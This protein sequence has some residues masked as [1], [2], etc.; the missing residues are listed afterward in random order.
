MKALLLGGILLASAS[1]SAAT[2]NIVSL[3]VT[4][5]DFEMT[6][7]L[8]AGHS[9]D[10]SSAETVNPA[11]D[12]IAGAVDPVLSFALANVVFG[13]TGSE[14]WLVTARTAGPSSA[15][16]DTVTNQITINLGTWLTSWTQ[17]GVVPPRQFRGCGGIY[18]ECDA[19]DQSPLGGLV[20]GTWNPA[21]NGFEVSWVR[22]IA[23]HPFPAGTGNWTLRGTAIVP[24]PGAGWLLMTALGGLA[25]L[26]LRGRPT[27]SPP[28]SNP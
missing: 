16:V 13:P 1:A 27:A 8:I 15:T 7:Q 9:G 4:D 17:T 25:A 5:F 10:T 20:T 18:P 6:P 11:A 3:T 22:D 21:T 28:R 12:L 2:I 23:A 26:R 24:L 14:A 19:L